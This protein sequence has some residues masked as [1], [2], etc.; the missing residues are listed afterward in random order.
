[1]TDGRTDRRTD[2]RTDGRTDG[3]RRLQYPRRFFKK[4]WEKS[5]G[6]NN[7]LYSDS[8]FSTDWQLRCLKEAKPMGTI[9]V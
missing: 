8:Y 6:D 5:V 3:R 1:M 4:A 7:L 2:R 9:L